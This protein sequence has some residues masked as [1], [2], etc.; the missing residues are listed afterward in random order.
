MRDFHQRL[1][2]A[3]DA[4]QAF[5]VSE[6]AV[7]NYDHDREPPPTYLA[8]V[9]DVFGY[10]LAWLITGEEPPTKAEVENAVVDVREHA[11]RHTEVLQGLALHFPVSRL[12]PAGKAAL[13]ELVHER[14][15]REQVVRDGPRTTLH[16]AA[17]LV[18]R[19]LALPLECLGLD[20]GR[21]GRAQR[22]LYV[23]AVAQAITAASAYQLGDG[24]GAALARVAEGGADGD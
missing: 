11:A 10:R 14:C 12:G 7:R 2:A 20:V 3:G 15:A 8:R 1:T 21:L 22:N 19:A 17:V 13:I 9:A 18:S 24:F 4:R 5:E 23:A 6:S 16:D